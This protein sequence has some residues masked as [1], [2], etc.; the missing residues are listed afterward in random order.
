MEQLNVILHVFLGICLSQHTPPCDCQ[1]ELEI[2]YCRHVRVCPEFVSIAQ[3]E[4]AIIEIILKANTSLDQV[5]IHGECRNMSV[6]KRLCMYAIK[7]IVL[8][9]TRE[10]FLCS[11]NYILKKLKCDWWSKITVLECKFMLIWRP[12]SETVKLLYFR[13][14][15][16]KIC[17]KKIIK[18]IYKIKKNS[19]N[20]ISKVLL[21]FDRNKTF[22]GHMT[23]SFYLKSANFP[24]CNHP[25]DAWHCYQSFPHGVFT[26]E[27][28]RVV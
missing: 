16:Y 11:G 10:S 5:L 23:S 27:R 9:S 22:F 6:Y 28:T 8:R 17:V 13:V 14:E 1:N 3:M 24:L 4:C 2:A 25:C 15:F 18:K 12:I 19:R 21:L 26:D 7:Q 20:W